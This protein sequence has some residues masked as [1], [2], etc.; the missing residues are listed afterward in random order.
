MQLKFFIDKI[1]IHIPSLSHPL[2]I[3][4]NY[5]CDLNR[6]EGALMNVYETYIEIVGLTFKFDDETNEYKNV[7]VPLAN[8]RIKI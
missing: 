2:K 7:A 1:N 4:T 8:Y 3:D 6:S 5:S